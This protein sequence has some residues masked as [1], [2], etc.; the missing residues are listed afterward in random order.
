MH[1][2]SIGLPAVCLV[3]LSAHVAYAQTAYTNSNA[4][5][6]NV[7]LIAPPP[8]PPMP[9][10]MLP[11]M[12][13]DH[14]VA[15]KYIQAPT[16]PGF[17]AIY[18][19]EGTTML[20]IHIDKTGLPI[21]I[22]AVESAGSRDLD[23]AAISAAIR[24]QFVPAVHNGMATDTWAKVPVAFHDTYP[25]PMLWRQA[26]KS[27]PVDID[28]TPMPYS[29]VSSASD[30]VAGWVKG[31][32]YADSDSPYYSYP[33]FD[34]QK[35]IRELW[36]FTDVSTNRAM[37]VRY[38]FA[39]TPDRPRIEVSTLCSDANL[40]QRRMPTIMAGPV[41]VHLAGNSASGDAS[42]PSL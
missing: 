20:L 14:G 13:G 34:D 22:K 10:Q 41:G 5:P 19:I 7:S 42:A 33:V 11:S 36:F 40:C 12:P 28:N 15:K 35:N 30:A 21:D 6:P 31:P 37:A 27:A 3:L 26:W 23:R 32:N 24:W 8:P 18:G 29:N 2:K 39:G 16:Y 25:G 4:T 1:G 38:V 17:E 9:P